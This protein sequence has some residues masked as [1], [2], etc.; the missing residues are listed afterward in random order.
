MVYGT[1]QATTHSCLCGPCFTV[2]CTCL[3][4]FF[5]VDGDEETFNKA[6]NPPATSDKDEPYGPGV[7]RSYM[8]K[9]SKARAA[10]HLLAHEDELRNAAFFVVINVHESMEGVKTDPPH[11]TAIR[12][13]LGVDDL[14][15]ATRQRKRFNVVTLNCAEIEETGKEWQNILQTTARIFKADQDKKR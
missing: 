14:M 6:L 3:L 1:F 9:M 2:T 15:Y 4:C 10:L 12:E 11:V 5:I 8:R 13:F 7:D